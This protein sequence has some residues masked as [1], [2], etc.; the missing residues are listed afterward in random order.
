MPS[1]NARISLA[2][3]AQVQA[4]GVFPSFTTYPA[5]F[6]RYLTNG[7][8]G[9]TISKVYAVTG[10]VGAEPTVLPVAGT[11]TTIKL[12]YVEN[13][14][15]A[16]GTASNVTTASAPVN[17]TVPRGQCLLATNDFV[18]W[19]AASVTI[20]GTAGAAYKIIALGN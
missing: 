3:T 11:L 1:S 14:G 12:W 19:P 9:Q 7:T 15:S 5:T 6:E 18:G 8:T 4:D 17:G 16:N 10:T 2:I 20:T 13:T